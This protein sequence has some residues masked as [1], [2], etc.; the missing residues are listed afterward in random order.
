LGAAGEDNN[1]GMGLIDVYAAFLSLGTPD[2][3]APDPIVD[4]SAGDPTSNSLTLQWTVPYD[5]SMNGV[6]GFD[7]RFSTSPINDTTTF[8]N[9]MQ[10]AFYNNTG[11]SRRNGNI[12]C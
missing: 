10:L 8:N 12:S 11:Y 6:T 1:Y 9:A 5:S 3:T 2:S 4:L 7:I